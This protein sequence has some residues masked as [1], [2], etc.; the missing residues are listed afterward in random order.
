MTRLL[1]LCLLWLAI[2]PALAEI[3]I[4][5]EPDPAFEDELITLT[6]EADDIEQGIDL[7][8]APLEEDFRVLATQV[9]NSLGME[10]GQ[11]VAKTRWVLHLRPR[12]KGML[13]IP[14]LTMGPHRTQ[15]REVTV[16][17][18]P[19]RT[20]RADGE[21]L[22]LEVEAE[23]LTPYVQQ[24]VR[25]TVRVLSARSMIQGAISDPQADQA[26]IRTLGSDRSY[27][28][29]RNGR[30][31]RDIERRYALFAERSGKLVIPGIRFE[32]RLAG[33]PS[34]SYLGRFYSAR[35]TSEPLV[36]EVRPRPDDYPGQHWLPAESLDL[37]E[38]WPQEP[39]RFQ[40][41]EPVTRTLI[42]QARGLTAAQLPEL[43]M[44]PVEGL[45]LYP[46]Q[47]ER[48]NRQDGP[49]VVGRLERRLAVVPS[50]PG[51][52]LL[53]E[54][55]L[56]WWDITADKPRRAVLPA[57][58]IQVAPALQA[59]PVPP[60]PEA[61]Q[62][63]RAPAQRP[64]FALPKPAGPTWPGIAAGLFILWLVTLLAW[65]RARRPVSLPQPQR[66]TA[67]PEPARADLEVACRNHDPAAAAAALRAWSRARWPHDPP[68]GAVALARRLGADPTP[69]AELNRVLYAPEADHWQGKP[70]WQA[71]ETAHRHTDGPVSTDDGLPPLYPVSPRPTD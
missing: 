13:T 42:L 55:E 11:L 53:P 4:R 7:N 54:I 1:F 28:T 20:D 51:E 31:Y 47:P 17:A 45:R 23:P 36:L 37:R 14:A 15:P 5:V 41:G 52:L 56:T 24:Q 9:G 57:R 27:Q 64:L 60:T 32:G 6:I 34:G 50:Q 69:F 29:S 59:E 44:A 46:D 12:R 39:P 3:D 25:L 26:L 67:D 43:E 40:V 30:P 63:S 21:D 18:R 66:L 38:A 19:V 10:Q 61:V 33:D 49:W 68:P 71:F 2:L 35:Q 22:L 58:T 62:P 70:L 16:V 48:E 65:W 8:T